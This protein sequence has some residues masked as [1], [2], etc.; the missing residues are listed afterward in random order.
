MKFG[1]H[2]YNAKKTIVDG[3]SFG[4]KLEAN[5][6]Q[7]VRDS[8]LDYELQKAFV[9]QQNFE[10]EGKK[11]QPIKYVCDSFILKKDIYVIDAKGMLLPAFN[12]KAKMFLYKFKTPIICVSSAKKMS[13]AMDMIK[14]GV[15]A[16]EINETLKPKKKKKLT[17]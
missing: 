13:M 16:S 7:V 8:G 5:C 6:Y 1:T 2:K 11:I 9:L 12:L 17:K 15:S 14:E 3:I 4:S 10:Y